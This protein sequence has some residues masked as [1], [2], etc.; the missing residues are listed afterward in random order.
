[1]IGRAKT[2]AVLDPCTTPLSQ[3]R[4][5]VSPADGWM[6]LL[7]H[8]PSLVTSTNPLVPT[9]SRPAVKKRGGSRACWRVCV[10]GR[11]RRWWGRVPLQFGVVC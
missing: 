5:F 7:A 8:V 9:S 6:T 4:T 10:V 11:M 2:L 3:T 1:M